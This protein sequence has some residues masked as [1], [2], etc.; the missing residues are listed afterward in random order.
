MDIVE[1]GGSYVYFT[2]LSPFATCL[3]NQFNNIW[4]SANNNAVEISKKHLSSRTYM[5]EIS[6]I[7]VRIC[8]SS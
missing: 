4:N 8:C 3:I 6:M 2:T 1:V 7:I 5:Y